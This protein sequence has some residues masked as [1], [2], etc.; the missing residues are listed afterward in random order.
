MRICKAKGKKGKHSNQTLKLHRV[1]AYS[2]VRCT[3]KTTELLLNVN[4]KPLKNTLIGFF[5]APHLKSNNIVYTYVRA[6]IHEAYIHACIHIYLHTHTNT[7]IY[8]ILA[9]I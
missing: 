5:K 6:H 8:N 4:I 2:K 7:Y 9:C 3:V 1:I